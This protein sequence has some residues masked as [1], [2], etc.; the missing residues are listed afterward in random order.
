[1]IP[2]IQ[3]LD[4]VDTVLG[5]LPQ[6]RGGE[7]VRVLEACRRRLHILSV[8]HKITAVQFKEY[9]AKVLPKLAEAKRRRALA[10][11]NEASHIM[12]AQVT[13]PHGPMY[14]GWYSAAVLG[15]G[16]LQSRF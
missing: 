2:N 13:G 8:S 4:H 14:Q 11:R 15:Y 1:M 3:T 10:R 16:K 7:R 5:R 9:N 12:I 6:W